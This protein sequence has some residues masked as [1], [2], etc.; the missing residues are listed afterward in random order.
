MVQKVPRSRCHRHL[1]RWETEICPYQNEICQQSTLHFKVTAGND[2]KTAA[3][4][5]MYTCLAWPGQ[6]LD[7]MLLRESS[8]EENS[9]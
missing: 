9:T 3:K 7:Q 6:G 4:F 2:S 5:C 1:Y 8:V